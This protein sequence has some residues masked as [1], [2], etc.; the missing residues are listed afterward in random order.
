M[1]FFNRNILVINFSVCKN[2]LR[3]KPWM[4]NITH[5]PCSNTSVEALVYVLYMLHAQSV[6][7]VAIFIPTLHVRFLL[8]AKLD[9]V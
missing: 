7:L 9:I 3:L 2:I 4:S 1:D 6:Y 5:G 8:G